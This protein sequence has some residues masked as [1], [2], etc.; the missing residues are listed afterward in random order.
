MPIELVAVTVNVYGVRLV[1]PVT[2]HDVVALVHVWPA[3]DVA[4][5]EVIAA[6][7]SD[8]VVQLT[9]VDALPPDVAET[10]V[11]ASGFVM[12]II[13]CGSS[14][15]EMTALPSVVAIVKRVGMMP[16]TE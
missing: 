1:R 11:G 4:V 10:P 9:V 6:P 8:V 14:V 12:A 3:F 2:E 5:Y 16:I 15:M 7:P 13:I